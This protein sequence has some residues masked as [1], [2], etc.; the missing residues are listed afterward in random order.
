MSNTVTL[1]RTRTVPV[2][3][4]DAEYADALAC[5]QAL[6]ISLSKLM[7]SRGTALPASRV[8]LSL[9]SELHRIGVNV[10][11]ITHALNA[12]LSPELSS[13]LATTTELM[14]ALTKLREQLMVRK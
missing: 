4:T 7:R 13:V 1:R 3:M 9:A 12:G 6:G 14:S 10:N 11:Q 5:A 2:R 8:D